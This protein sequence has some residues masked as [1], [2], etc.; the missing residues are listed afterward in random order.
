MSRIGSNPNNSS[1]LFELRMLPNVEDYK[2]GH[3]DEDCDEEGEYIDYQGDKRNTVYMAPWQKKVR[4][5]GSR[6]TKV[7]A[8]R[9]TGKSAF[10]AFNMADVT[11]GLARMMGGFC[12]ASAKQNYTRTMPNVLKVMNLLGFVE[13]VHYFLG[14][15]PARLGWPTP[16][17]KPRVWENCVS[18]ANGFVWQMISLAVKGSA[19]G[20]NLAAIMGDET[21]YMPWQRVKEEVLPT[22]R[23]DFLPKAY[24][25]TEQKRWGYGTDPKMNNKWLSQLW[26]SD[27]GLNARECL[28]EKEAE[29]ETTDVNRKIEEMMAEVRYAEL[30]DKEH[31]TNFAARLAQSEDY[32][33]K[34]YALRTQSETFWRFS[35]IENAALLGG[36]AWIR[37]MQRELPDLLFRLQILN[38]PRGSAKDG[39]Y[40]NFSELNT[41][42]SEEITDLVFDKYSTRVK[43]RALDGQRWPTDFE[44]ESLEWDQL[45][46][47]GEDC[48]LDL[49][50]DYKEPLCIA[51]DANSDINCFVV[52]QRRIFQGKPSLLVM[53]EFFV[54]DGVRLRGLSK[55]FAQYYRP[56]LRRGCKEVIFYVA[57][58]IKQGANKAYA[59]EESEQSRFDVV[60]TDELTGYGFKVTRAEFT[61]WRHERKYQYVN[62]CFSGQASPSVFIN[63]EAGRCVYLRAALENT[64]VVP[65]T[66][67]KYKGAEKLTSE[68]GIGGD[69]RQRTTITDAFDDLL[70]GIKE[71]AESKHKVGGRLRGRFENLAGIPR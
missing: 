2:P 43:G 35:S 71:C 27:A 6:S 34:L 70:I 23:G 16:L 24:R 12:G 62:D 53:K 8:G 4:N 51:L 17:A 7:L 68:E 13:G 58:S 56:F 32:L 61:S 31:H 60:V 37:Q 42:V 9:G 55:L 44:T 14:R 28:W 33:R 67:R 11:I 15:P 39:F 46:H 57:S 36:E 18:F 66:F 49:D 20:L 26:V 40:C 69:K 45:Q 41:Y 38:Q 65:G 21:K 30:Y 47:D 52:G 10:L 48:S 54:Q 19:N 1:D 5:F 64:A 22:L 59:L 63:R 25:K 50:L 29:Y 3:A